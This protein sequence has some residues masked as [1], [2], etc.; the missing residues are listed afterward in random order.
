[1]IVEK[2]V[3]GAFLIMVWQG[4]SV[5]ADPAS[6]YAADVLSTVLGNPTSKYYKR[7]IDSGLTFSSGIGYYT[8]NHVGPITAFSQL[9]PDKILE[10]RRVI[11]EE[12]SKLADTTY[13]TAKELAAAQRQL[14]INTLYEREQSTAWAHT[15]GFWWAVAGLDYYRNYVPNMQRITRQD[16][17]RYARSYIIG[18]P[19]VTGVLIG[20]DDRTKLALTAEQVL[21]AGGTR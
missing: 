5:T 6:T 13:I 18:K 16:I 8:L 21:A 10:A 7:L 12:L 4:P 19:F 17:A 3:N 2:P 14:G 15:V 11:L 1:M 9:A 20:P